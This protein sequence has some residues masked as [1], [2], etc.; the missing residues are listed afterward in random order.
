MPRT[1]GTTTTGRKVRRP[2]S[3]AARGIADQIG[4]IVSANAALQRANG[5]L[6]AENQ[7]LK[8]ELQEIG[9]ALGRLTG[10]GRRRRGRP[11]VRLIPTSAT[12]TPRRTR[13]PITDPAV[14]EKRREALARARQVRA[15]RLAAAKAGG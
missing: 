7:R 10:N 14:L 12:A 9:N 3:A 15:E 8:A 6:S 4:Q 13:R 1:P 5:E 11:S 2:R